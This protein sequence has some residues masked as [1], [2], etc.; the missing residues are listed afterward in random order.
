MRR[1]WKSNKLYIVG[2]AAAVVTAAA[3]GVLTTQPHTSTSSTETW[4][5]PNVTRADVDTAF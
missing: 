2:S 1:W 3:L 4:T 5:V